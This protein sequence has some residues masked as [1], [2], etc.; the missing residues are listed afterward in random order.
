LF[1][2]GDITSLTS[3]MVSGQVFGDGG[4]VNASFGIIARSI[5][6]VDAKIM[7]CGTGIELYD[8]MSSIIHENIEVCGTG[9]HL[10]K[11]Q[12]GVWDPY[13]NAGVGGFVVPG[14]RPI[15]AGFIEGV[16]MESNTICAVVIDAARNLTVQGIS[17]GQYHPVTPAN[18]FYLGSVRNCLFRDVNFSGAVT[19]DCV[20]GQNGEQGGGCT[21]ENCYFANGWTLPSGG[22]GG[23]YD[24][25]TNGYYDDPFI[26]RNCSGFDGGVTK[27]NLPPHPS[28]D[29]SA[30]V[31]CTNSDLPAWD[32]VTSAALSRRAVLLTNGCLRAGTARSPTG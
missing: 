9:I 1:S 31:V 32:P 11:T 2:A 28:V 17:H 29:C 22:V 26:F 30:V 25:G 18:S 3:T 8:G 23:Y 6:I 4:A 14:V 24:N 21:F 12:L 15:A 13:A 20:I 10:G 19:R 27:A 16:D 7:L 5:R